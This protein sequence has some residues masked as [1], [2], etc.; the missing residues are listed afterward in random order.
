MRHIP[1]IAS[2][3]YYLAKEKLCFIS[4][5]TEFIN[6]EKECVF[7]YPFNVSLKIH[8]FIYRVFE[9]TW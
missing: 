9:T 4:E 2:H 6:R 7:K 1:S 8:L 5:H 3:T